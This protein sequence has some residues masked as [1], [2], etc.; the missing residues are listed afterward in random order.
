MQGYFIHL[1]KIR[2]LF[3][4]DCI[5]TSLPFIRLTDKAGYAVDLMQEYKAPAL[6]VVNEGVLAGTISENR[7][8]EA[9]D[10]CLI[11]SLRDDLISDSIVE[12]TH[13]FDVIKKT[14]EH[15]SYFMPVINSEKEYIGI[16]TPQ[17]ILNIL[18]L[19]SSFMSGGGIIVLELETKDYSLTEI[20]KIVESNGA[21]ILHCMVAT[22][23]NQHQ[24]QVS[25]KVN[26]NDL[27]DIQ[28]TFERYR[29]TV[30][31]V[32]HQ[33]EYEMQ[34]KERYDSLMRYLEV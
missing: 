4:Q 21:M 27:K 14:S 20:S 30:L 16:T 34:L 24:M 9:D 2:P 3:V 18:A 11:E 5:D 10:L 26:K 28:L 17:K 15:S 31:S 25:L 29:Y 1:H 33:S 7:L 13:L 6:A 8:L 32:L 22:S 19:H 23:V 12:G